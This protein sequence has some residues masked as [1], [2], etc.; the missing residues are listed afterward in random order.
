MAIK[1]VII[2]D[3]YLARENLKLLLNDFCEDVEIIG[4]ADNIIEAKTKIEALKPDVVFL[5]IRM[6]SGAEG[7]DLLDN[8]KVIDFKIVFVTA[9]KDY[10]L[11]AFKANAIDYILKPVE[12]EE[13]QQVVQKLQRGLPID[14]TN[15][16][17][18]EIIDNTL[19]SIEDKA[20]GK[21]A[22]SH[23]KG[24]T[25]INVSD[26]VRLQSNGNYTE[27]YL[28]DG[29]RLVDSKTLKV[30]QDILS[31]QQFMRVHH[32]HLISIS[33]IVGYSSE[34]GHFAL[35]NSGDAIPI[36]RANLSIFKA[37]LN[38]YKL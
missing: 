7:F 24:M 1:T 8:L 2:D 29:T 3:E 14:E 26:I 10:A 6:P 25:L 13:L 11:K 20:I 33:T 5:D 23:A 19:Q 18:K 17:S 16:H 36:S 38:Q 27:V 34:D 37:Y 30:Y 28:Q 9:F 31:D 32:S 4:E 35:L 12:I 15:F 22:V 21:I